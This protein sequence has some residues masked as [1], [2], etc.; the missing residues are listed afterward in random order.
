MSTHREP[1]ST[2][3]E[4]PQFAGLALLLDGYF[5]QDFRTEFADHLAAARAFANEASAE[6]LAAARAAL[7]AFIEWAPAVDRET[8]QQALNRSGGA[9]RPRSLHPLVEVA[10]A[11]ARR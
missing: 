9:W 11:L 5:H 8:W 2:Q 3:D 6:E 1:D 10:E 4:A 7:A